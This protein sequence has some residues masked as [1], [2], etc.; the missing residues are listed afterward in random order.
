M[1]IGMVSL[2]FTSKHGLCGIGFESRMA[3][4]T[5]RLP[6]YRMASHRPYYVREVLRAF[7]GL[8]IMFSL[9]RFLQSPPSC[10]GGDWPVIRFDN[11]YIQDSL[12][13]SYV[14]LE[15]FVSL[16]SYGD[17]NDGIDG[18]KRSQTGP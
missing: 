3:L 13:F 9:S 8:V 16:W 10:F 5:K 15:I 14:L 1:S 18:C 4:F 2:Y 11:R 17:D 6:D 12:L 7:L